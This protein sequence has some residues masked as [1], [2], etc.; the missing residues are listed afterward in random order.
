MAKLTKCIQ[1]WFV[2]FRAFLP[3][4]EASVFLFVCLP[5]LLSLLSFLFA[6]VLF[7]TMGFLQTKT[8]TL[9]F[10]SALSALFPAFRSD[11]NRPESATET[12]QATVWQVTWWAFLTPNP[13][14]TPEPSW[15]RAQQS[16]A[17]ALRSRSLSLESRLP[18]FPRS[19]TWTG[20]LTSLGLSFF[21]CK[22][23]PTPQ[24]CGVLN[25]AWSTVKTW[26]T[27]VIY[28]IHFREVLSG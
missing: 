8:S 2:I 19:R 10:G 18:C 13:R 20:Y 17:H 4:L 23:G 15:S 14:I 12:E 9:L 24:G 25:R 5:C 28:N 27:G 21:I 7:L 3:I 22:I 1:S 11:A 26:K 16:W 6:F